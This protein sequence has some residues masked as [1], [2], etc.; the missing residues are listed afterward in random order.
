MTSSTSSFGPIRSAFWPIHTHELRKLLPMWA[1]LFLICFSYSILRNAKD[2]VVV[3]KMGAEA[4]PFIKVWAMLPTAVFL[5]ILFAKLSNRFSFT[6]VFY[7]MITLFLTV[8]GLF[9]YVFYP[10]Q[11]ML[12]PTTYAATIQALLPPGCKGLVSMFCYWSHTLF[13]VI[14]ELWS[15]AILGVLFWGFANAVTS[16]GEARRFYGVLGIGAS[17]ASIVAGQ[18]ANLVSIEGNSWEH[19]LSLLITIVIFCGISCMLLF[20][21]MM[22]HVFNG[23]EYAELHQKKIQTGKKRLS[24]SESFSHLSKSKYLICIAILVV[25]YNLVIHM[26]EVIWKDQLGRL[27]P[28]PI[29]YNMYMNNVTTATGIFATI[30]AIFMA[31]CI[32]TLGW[33]GTAM[34]TPLMLFVTCAGF[35]G[36]LFFQDSL[37]DFFFAFAGTTPLALAVFFGAAQNALSKAAKYSVF[38]ATKEMSFIPLDPDSRF[39]GKTAIDGVGS[40]IGK[41]G[42]A[43]M[44][45]GLLIAFGS[46]MASAPYVVVILAITLVLWMFA[47]SS[48]GKQ[49]NSLVAE[50]E[51]ND[52]SEKKENVSSI[53][54]PIDSQP[55]P[56][57]S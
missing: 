51:L 30:A 26:T 42:G 44:H 49:F 20:S 2:A 23:P 33:T 41:S 13:Y 9:A 21:W 43:I 16:V 35:F 48:L 31:K 36:C 29:D 4:L 15:T 28:S 18:I 32:S 47:V 12:H 57:A 19:T 6:K 24:M 8:F 1:I 7:I 50:N 3:T 14:S 54:D 25:A 10:L 22:R 45:Q 11:D 37:A 38:D 27:Y 56:V 55:A 39:K 53:K 34:I 17:A 40:R 52:D 46:F 5:T